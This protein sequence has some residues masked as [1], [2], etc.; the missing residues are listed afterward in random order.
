[1][2]LTFLILVCLIPFCSANQCGISGQATREYGSILGNDDEDQDTNRILGGDES[3]EGRWPWI[4]SIASPVETPEG[5]ATL[6]CTGTII[7]DRWIL[8]AAHCIKNSTIYVNYGSVRKIDS[9][10]LKE[11]PEINKIFVYPG[12]DIY[13]AYFGDIALL[14]LKQKIIFD[15]S[16]S[17]ISGWGQVFNYLN[18]A[19]DEEDHLPNGDLR[20]DTTSPEILNERVIT[21]KNDESCK[22]TIEEVGG[23]QNYDHYICHWSTNSGNLPGDSGGPSMAFRNG[24]WIQVGV[25]SWGESYTRKNNR[26]DLDQYLIHT[27]VS[28]Y[29]DWIAATTDYAVECLE[30][31]TTDEDESPE[32]E[33]ME[34]S[35]STTEMPLTNGARFRNF[36]IITTVLAV[37]LF[38][39]QKIGL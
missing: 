28:Y 1:M 27:R 7:G 4:V 17:P 3:V 35:T 39:W 16:V 33:N 32:N 12:Y 25:T 15:E 37:V 29:C 26:I 30:D 6:F 2:K 20:A 36:Q 23:E 38:W 9:N 21:V 22:I 11:Y 34:N 18:V 8:T 10:S 5:E 13:Q 19:V 24:V 14:K 31:E